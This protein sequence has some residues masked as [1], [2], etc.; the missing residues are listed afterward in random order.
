MK[1]AR[2]EALFALAAFAVGCGGAH[3]AA[4]SEP[5]ATVRA[6]PSADPSTEPAP[7]QTAP[8]RADEPPRDPTGGD[9]VLATVTAAL[10]PGASVVSYSREGAH[11]RLVCAASTLQ[12]VTTLTKSLSETSGLRD[13]TVKSLKTTATGV[14][15]ELGFDA[16]SEAPVAAAASADEPIAP[17]RPVSVL[18]LIGV[19]PASTTAML[20]D[21]TQH[22]WV[23]HVGDVVGE[24]ER[25]AGCVR[26]WR[27]A[28]IAADRVVLVGKGDGCSTTRRE[29]L[30]KASTPHP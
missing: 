3:G 16:V 26:R 23:V 24:E 18:V 14:E 6:I 19:A 11:V 8:A 28:R 21:D 13:V 17:D 27:V 7:E 4:K 25:S 5:V 1:L 22:G 2:R 29:L 20:V 30:L 10:P 15:I 12:Q 9:P